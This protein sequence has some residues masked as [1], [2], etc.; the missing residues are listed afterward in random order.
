MEKKLFGTD[1]IRGRAN[2]FPLNVEMITKIGMAIG[3]VLRRKGHRNNIV[4]GKDTRLSGYMIEN[5]LTAGLNAVGIDVLL[6]GPIPTP[7]VAMLTKSMKCDIGI[8]I[9]AS[10]NPYY[11][12][13]IKLFDS[14]GVK[15][16]DEIEKQIEDCLAVNCF[17][18]FLAEDD[19]LGKRTV[20]EHYLYQQRYIQFLKNTFPRELT[21]DGIRIALDCANGAAYMIAPTILEELGAKVY[22]IGNQPNGVN[23]NKECGSTDIRKLQK[24]VVEKECDIGI[25]L[26]GDADRIIIVDENGQ[27]I[28]GD[29]IIGLVAKKMIERN[30][31]RGQTVVL[32]QMSNLGLEKYL[33]SLGLNVIRTKVGDRYVAEKMREGNFNLGGEQSGHIILGDYSTTGD[34]TLVALQVLSMLVKEKGKKIS[35]ITNLYQSVPQLLKNVEFDKNKGNPLEEESVKKVIEKCEEK[36]KGNGRLLIRKSGTQPLIRVMAESEDPKIMENVVNDIVA[37]IQKYV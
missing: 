13:G 17:M 27:E 2:Q 5:A 35:E 24:L 29:K 7:G 31:L 8:V 37:E 6:L 10:H 30:E 25:A 11:D 32:T 9:S 1:G 3:A 28:D 34:G 12:N 26:D 23:I 16:P 19:K 20:S 15:F 33:N 22:V 4:I 14:N 36:L 21:L 18:G